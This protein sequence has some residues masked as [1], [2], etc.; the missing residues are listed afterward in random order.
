MAK[1]ARYEGSPQDRRKDRAAEKR[2]GM[3][4]KQWEQS[5]ADKKA[6]A[7]GQRALDRKAK[8]KKKK[9]AK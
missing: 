9:K 2:T 7:A 1:A 8:A 3:T 6:D 4:A 5:A